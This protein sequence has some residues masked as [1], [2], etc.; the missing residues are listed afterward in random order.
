MDTTFGLDL[1]RVE[2]LFKRELRRFD[3]LHPRSAQAYRENRRHWL[4]GAPLHWMQQWPGNCPLLVKE[5]QGARVT[6]I[7]GQQYV[8][9]A[10]GDSGAMFGHA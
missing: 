8:D 4:Y 5:A 3:E 1:A 10:L 2:A 7:D 9:F 6:D